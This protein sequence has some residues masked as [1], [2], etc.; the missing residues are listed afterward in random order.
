MAEQVLTV[1]E[2]ASRLGVTGRT[3]R[4]MIERGAFPR[5]YQLDPTT[6]KSPYRIPVGDVESI[7]QKRKGRDSERTAE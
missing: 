5:A 6:K 4:N 3:V 1:E 7:E 2:V